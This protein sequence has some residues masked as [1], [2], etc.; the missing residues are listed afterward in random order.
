M[1]E[2]EN[3]LQEEKTYTIGKA[4]NSMSFILRSYA[5]FQGE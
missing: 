5:R 1:L 4:T 2:A 3:G